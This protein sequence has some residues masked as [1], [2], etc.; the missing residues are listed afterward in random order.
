MDK[1]RIIPAD[2]M[3]AAELPVEGVDVPATETAVQVEGD[4][5]PNTSDQKL[6]PN[7]VENEGLNDR[8]FREANDVEGASRE[9]REAELDAAQRGRT[10]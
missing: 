6:P 7:F 4:N 8:Q 2:P 3:G 9:G 10:A 5:P 1:P